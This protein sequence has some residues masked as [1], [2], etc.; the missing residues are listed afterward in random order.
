MPEKTMIISN[1]APFLDQIFLQLRAKGIEV[2]G[3]EMDHICYRVESVEQYESFKKMLDSHGECIN[4][5]QIAGR[6][7]ALYKLHQP[8]QYEGRDIYLFELPAPKASK[9]YKEGYEHVEFVIDTDLETFIAAYPHLDFDLKGMDKKINPDVRI[10]FGAISVKFHLHN[11]EYVVR[12][13][14]K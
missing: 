6:P 12:Y 5:S 1:P 9:F 4:E 10:S 2:L 7:I 14:D 8:I 3:F 11:L 13:L